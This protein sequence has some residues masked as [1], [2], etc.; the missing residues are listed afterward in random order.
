MAILDPE[1]QAVQAENLK[2]YTAEYKVLTARA[3][4]MAEARRKQS[5]VCV[6]K[7][8]GII[9]AWRAYAEDCQ[10]HRQPMTWAGCA[11]AA[12]I[13][14]DTLRR[15]REGELDHVIEEF[16]LIHDIPPDSEAWI[17]PEGEVVP[18]IPLSAVVE[19]CCA[20]PIMEQLESNC[21]QLKGNQVG[22][23]FGLK[24]KFGWQDEAQNTITHNT[25]VV[26]DK[27]KALSILTMLNPSDSND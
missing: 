22:S 3:K 26:A 16:R 8:P 12:G 17:S 5:P 4:A 6:E 7:L 27:D 20:L 1:K 14:Y 25:L 9:E 18:L 23:I 2:G 11:L 15:M 24:A 10:A 21:Y 19:K 13:G